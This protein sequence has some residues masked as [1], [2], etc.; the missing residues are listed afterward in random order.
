MEQNPL[1]APDPGAFIWTILAFL[2]LFFLLAKFAWKPL[3]AALDA[4]QKTIAKA[5]DDARMAKE[6]YDRAKQEAGQILAKTRVEAEAI[7]TRTRADAD[8]FREEMRQKA[9]ADAQVIV[10][11]AEKEIQQEANRAVG[12]LRR[13]A[14]ELSIAIASKILHRN[15][16]KDDNVALIEDAI[17]QFGS[18]A[19]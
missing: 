10:Q 1:T 12:Q 6:E 11:R 17:K 3:L 7:M 8:Q 18:T 16:S 9:I 5:L 15:I 2:T 19:N 4:R 14:G 13:E